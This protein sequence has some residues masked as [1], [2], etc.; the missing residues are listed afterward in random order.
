MSF[1]VVTSLRHCSF[2]LLVA[3][4]DLFFFLFLPLFS[5]EI[6]S[7]NLLQL[8]TLGNIEQAVEDREGR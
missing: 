3:V 6:R 2:D 1:D 4:N 5:A 8:L 7:T